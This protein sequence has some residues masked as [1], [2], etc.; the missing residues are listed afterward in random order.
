MTK[1]YFAKAPISEIANEI[2]SKF[3]E[4]ESWLE[5]SGY[6]AKVQSLYNSY[7]AFSE[8]GFGLQY[9][10]NNTKA[11]V[12]VNHFKSLIQRLHSLT[13]QAK[14]VYVPRSRNSDSKSQLEAD[15]AK[16]LLEFFADEKDM[17]GVISEMVERGL[18][19]LDSFVYAP[20]REDEGEVIAQGDQL[21]EIRN[22]DQSF[23]VL[24]RF[25]VATHTKLK[26]S[27]YH[28]VREQ[29]NRF[30]LASIY[31]EQADY[32]LSLTAENTERKLI[33]PFNTET[34]DDDLIEILT[35][36][37]DRTPSLNTGR[38]TVIAG[39]EVLRD[40]ALPYK[41]IPIVHFKPS[42]VLETVVGDS[43]A[44]SLI[45]MQ[46]VIDKLWSAVTT[47]NLHYSQQNLWAPTDIEIDRISEG[48]NQIKSPTKPEAINLVQSSPETYKLIDSLQN[49]E[50]IISGINATA[51]G[52]PEA[53]LKSGTS[54]SLMLA[55]A[56]QFADSIQ[57]EYARCSSDLATIVIHNLQKF[58]TE[59]R[60]AYIGGLSKKSYV[61]EF[62]NT[63][64]INIDRVSVDIG[65][66]LTQNIAGRY[67]LMQQWMQYG[68]VKDP[69]KLIEFMRTGQID[70]VTEDDFKDSVLVREENERLR[71]GELPPVAL[72]DRHD[73]HILEHKTL[74]NDFA[75]RE[76][77]EVINN[78]NAH[79]QEH[80]D[81][82]K[83]IDPDLAAILGIQ[84]L[85]SQ[86]NPVPPN[87]PELN[88]QN[89][90]PVPEQTPPQFQ[91]AY[92]DSV[93]FDPTLNPSEE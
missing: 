3:K 45:S 73:I 36:I 9:T 64:V 85:P 4:Y 42:Q 92:N 87:D 88:G 74:T 39:R 2:H 55:V 22:G 23:K 86:S 14:L 77:P 71:K 57:K 78:I 59:P 53:S 19:M 79:I 61:K 34:E 49:N 75:I 28:I 48:Y 65:N 80:L 21:K 89:L 16:G 12:K 13:T 47:N 76:N 81:Q 60:L 82:I 84:P 27:P 46:Q 26:N 24:S 72:Y 70:S 11:K 43:P 7:Y 8:G 41:T 51:R 29:V 15:F 10:E 54:L 20:W 50:Q 31:P 5:S 67:E 93:Q 30:D 1:Q 91:Q 6:A 52:T 18:V 63:D 58:A 35:L 38:L 69:K 37:H 62:K 66:P 56:V 68:I 90:P 33:T 32:I 44:T 83:S 25:D 40:T 17:N